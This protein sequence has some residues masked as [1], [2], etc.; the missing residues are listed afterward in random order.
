MGVAQKTNAYPRLRTRPTWAEIS[1]KQLAENFSIVRQHLPAQ[2]KILSVVKADAY[3]HGLEEV[4][5]VLAEART[6]W[7]GVTSADEGVELR[8][9]GMT[10][11]VLLLTGFW[12]GELEALSEYNLTPAI[13]ADDQLAALED[14]GRQKARKMHFHLKINTG[15]G[16]L[17]LHWQDV[18]RF[19]EFYRAFQHTEMEGLFTHLASSE[20]YTSPQTEQQVERFESV[21]ADF[22]KAGIQPR[23]IH[24]AN[25]AA[26]AGRPSTWGNMVRPG[27]LLY[28]IQLPLE[29]R[30]GMKPESVSLP[31]KNILTWKSRIIALK[32]VPAGTPLGYGAGYVT[33]KTSRIA[34]IPAGYADGLKRHLSNRGRT[35]VRDHYA[36]IIGN[37]SMDLTLLDVTDIPGVA[38]GDEVILIGQSEH[39]SVTPAEISALSRTV[40]YDVLCAVSKRVPR[41]YLR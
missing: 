3:G 31:V 35:I 38:V 32:E 37:I 40:P 11:P 8:E 36:A 39:C 22:R 24:L 6:D 25:S 7:F 1:L 10:Q 4:S 19:L 33:Q 2:V 23:Y 15:M 9:S 28:G 26:I 27:A 17:G 18:A 12:R 20:D 14:W 16:R 30:E 13:Y 34:T 21:L 29:L 5:R 41:I